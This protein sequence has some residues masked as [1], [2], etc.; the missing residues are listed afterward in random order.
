M[1]RRV[2]FSR[3][4][5]LAVARGEGGGCRRSRF[6]GVGSYHARVVTVAGERFGLVYQMNSRNRLKVSPRP[7][8]SQFA[9]FT[10]VWS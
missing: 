7:S 6:Y 8:I 10:L 3:L 5:T 1:Q 9:D 2:G 4:C